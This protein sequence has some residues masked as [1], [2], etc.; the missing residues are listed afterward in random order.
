MVVEWLSKL[1]VFTV[2]FGESIVTVKGEFGSLC[3]DIGT[4]VSPDEF[5]N[6][7]VEVKLDL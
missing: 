5:L 1:E 4:G 6:W 7:V 2:L 3:G